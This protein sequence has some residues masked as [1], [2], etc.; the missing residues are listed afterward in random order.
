M[1]GIMQ[2][3]KR[4]SIRA[5]FKIELSTHFWNIRFLFEQEPKLANYNSSNIYFTYM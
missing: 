3:E 4:M 2:I 1:G 5:D